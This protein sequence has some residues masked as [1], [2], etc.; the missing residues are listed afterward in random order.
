MHRCAHLLL[1]LLAALPL[2]AQ[3]GLDSLLRVLPGQR[4]AD[5]VRTLGEVE[6]ALSFTDPGRALAY[7]QE[8]LKLAVALRDSAL[9]AQA[10]NDLAIPEYRLGHYTSCI[11]L[12]RRALAIRNTLKDSTGIA[13]SHSKLGVAFTEM[14]QLDSALHHNQQ[15]EAIYA[16]QGDLVRLGTMRGNMAR[17]YQQMGDIPAA[18]KV[19]R[20]TVAMLEGTG[21][22]YVYANGLGQL[23]QILVD[24]K[25][26]DS[27]MHYARLALPLFESVDDRA[28]IAS[29]SNV[30]GICARERGDNAA[31]LEHYTRALRMAGDVGDQ[32]GVATYLSNVAN[33]LRDLGH[34][35]D[36]CQRYDSAIALCAQHGFADQHLSALLG[37]VEALKR[38][39]DMTAALHAQ[40]T[41]QL[42]KDSAY[43]RERIEAISDMQVRYETERTEKELAQEREHVLEQ[44]A[45]IARQR[46]TIVGVVLVA[47]LIAALAWALIARQRARA[48]AE[49][50]A[51][52][53]AEREHGLRTVVERMDEDRRRIAA[54][55][56]DGVGQHLTGIKYR[57]EA[58]AAGHPELREVLVMADDAGREVR[59]IAHRM[60]P[61]ALGELGLV[62]ALADM[63]EKTLKLPGMHHGFEHFGL[64]QRL[65]E[66][67][68]V[69]VYRIAQELINNI[70]K[71]ARATSVQV[72]LLRNKGTLVLIVEDDGVGL[73]LRRADDGLGLR[74]LRDRARILQGSI[75][76]EP[77][78]ERGTVV[79]LRIPL[80]ERPMS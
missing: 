29:L 17:L 30:M 69:G 14:L 71:H 46:L 55:L 47:V 6:W 22:N 53:I 42:L 19:A 37:K 21:E 43:R 5:R 76:F 33:V 45:R 44:E 31:A 64:E 80:N 34:L 52:V 38:M 12:N 13:A 32:E 28:A 27:A 66:A 78:A 51:A 79:T 26:P 50:D 60:M 35:E 65:P 61:R 4:G 3:D 48:R 40:Q 77:G 57:L 8:A 23:A 7:G 56:H 9:V 54:E 72:Q 11:A 63:L 59:G 74:S 18:L 49:R 73:D 62:P 67:V 70:V 2:Y 39:G 25:Q 1:L 36:A 41:Y 68:E 16:A 24:V 10:A 15:A 58:A 75:A 20:Q